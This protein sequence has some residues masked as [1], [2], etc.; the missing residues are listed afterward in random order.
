M[1]S[2]YDAYTLLS[3][4]KEQYAEDNNTWNQQQQIQN[5]NQ[6]QN[7]YQQQPIQNSPIEQIV[8]QKSVM[9]VAQETPTVASPT[10]RPHQ[11]SYIEMMGSKR[12]EIAK[13]IGYALM[14]LFA[15]T[16]YTAI[17]FWLK[18]LVEKHDWSF[19]QELGVRLAYPFV[20]L[21][22]LWNFKVL[23]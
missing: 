9:L 18:E 22:L 1:T 19:K 23:S 21:F 13:V 12:K 17:D 11:P 10:P 15:L 6:I 16:L 8:P 3:E 20:V 2:L 5:S 14:I 4:N 7:S